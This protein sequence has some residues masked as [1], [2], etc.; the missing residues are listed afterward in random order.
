MIVGVVS[1]KGG[2]GKSTITRLLAREYAANKWSVK[3]ADM[4]AKQGTSTR[5]NMLRNDNQIEPTIKIE[6]YRSV[7]DA[8][9]D[10]QKGDFHLM[11]FDGAPASSKITLQIAQNSNLVILPTGLSVDD[12][13]PTVRLAHELVKNNIPKK[14]II[15]V[16]CRA[17]ESIS[18]IKDAQDYIEQVGYKVVEHVLPDRVAYRRAQDNGYSVSETNFKSLNNKSMKLTQALIDALTQRSREIEYG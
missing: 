3:I 6:Q 2:V 17:G 15:M 8:V 10:Y 5:W 13:E 16:F 1:Q 11:I 9:S 4:D 18:E 7:A 12:L 14:D